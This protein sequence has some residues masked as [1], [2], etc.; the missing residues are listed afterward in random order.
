VRRASSIWPV[1]VLLVLR[2]RWNWKCQDGPTI[3][4]LYP[5]KRRW[6]AHPK[7]NRRS[8]Q[9]GERPSVQATAKAELSAGRLREAV[10]YLS[11]TTPTTAIFA[12]QPCATGQ[13]KSRPVR[14]RKPAPRQHFTRRAL[15]TAALTTALIM[16]SCSP[17]PPEPAPAA[18]LSDSPYLQF[19]L[20]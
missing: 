11:I 6:R 14:R 16:F 2:E 12:S 3:G 15:P 5:Y 13:R 1:L 18:M 8:T 7:Q 19:S 4:V 9:V 17:L 10:I 20:R